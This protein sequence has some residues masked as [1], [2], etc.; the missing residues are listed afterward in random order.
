MDVRWDYVAITVL[1]IA[2]LVAGVLAAQH[3]EQA[4]AWIKTWG[5]VGVFFAV[6]ITNATLFIG[7]PTPTYILL[8]VALG[9]NPV[10]V[11]VVSAA[12]SAIGESTGYF[13]G[14]GSKKLL[15]SRYRSFYEKWEPVFQKYS[16]LTVL[17]IAALPIPPDDFAGL[18]A[19]SVEYSYPKFI[20]ATFLGKFLKYLAT[21]ALAVAGI[22]F[23]G[24]KW[25]A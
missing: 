20:L 1:V 25:G 10:L 8:A 18:L 3:P 13:V 12:G 15:E 5:Y 11:A 6:M 4:K 14:L 22:R 21:A 9:M 16:F 7:I 24:Q 2:G 19:G 17:T 23:A